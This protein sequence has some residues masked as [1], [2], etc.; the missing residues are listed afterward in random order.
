[1]T[2]RKRYSAEFKSSVV[3]E[4]LREE[5]TINEIASKYGIAPTMLNRWKAEFLENAH[6]VF[7]RE[8]DKHEKR[9]KEF[10]EK[11]ENLKRLVG[12]LTVE[13]DWLKKKSGLK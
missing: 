10:E 8:S 3:L 5:A 12:Q 11:E 6:S 13:I 1:M 9:V 7:E 4:A 2:N